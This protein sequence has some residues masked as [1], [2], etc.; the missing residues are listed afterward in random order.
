VEALVDYN[1][2]MDI[3]LSQPGGQQEGPYD[4]ERINRD[5][6]S[7]KYR[8]T[9]Y[10][11]W[12]EGQEAWVP[13]HSIPG[14]VGNS[15][16]REPVGEAAPESEALEAATELE[17]AVYEDHGASE[18][19]AG[20]ENET[21]SGSVGEM[22]GQAKEE[23]GASEQES[24]GE[25]AQEQGETVEPPKPV[26]SGMP[27]EALKQ[28]FIFTSGEGGAVVQS[29]VTTRMLED[30]IGTDIGAIRERAPREV[31]GRCNIA[32]R[33]VRDGKVPESAWKAV[34]AIRPEIMKEAREG[35]YRTCV[36]TFRIET[37][38]SVA[39]FLFYDKQTA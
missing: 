9:D 25:M 22:E 38:D 18:P 13:L 29:P 8:D 17:T 1:V 11:A 20:L 19:E 7:N 14:V 31:V 30:V 24:K 37:D 32:E 33:L 10:W 2:G 6:A 5:L 28:I 27:A 39:V 36:R 35:R 4:L 3:Y 12:Y 21:A 16:Q 26:A 15:G 23:L 34:S